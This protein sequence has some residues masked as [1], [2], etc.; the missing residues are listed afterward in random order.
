MIHLFI[1]VLIREHIRVNISVVR[2]DIH[3]IL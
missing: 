1:S 2:D 3:I